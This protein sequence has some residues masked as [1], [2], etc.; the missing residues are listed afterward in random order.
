ML[1]KIGFISFEVRHVSNCYVSPIGHIYVNTL[2]VQANVRVRLVYLEI[3]RAKKS[4]LLRIKIIF[5]FFSKSCILKHISLTEK[6][7]AV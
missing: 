5:F 7:I 4:F 1:L 2:K 6:K 3:A